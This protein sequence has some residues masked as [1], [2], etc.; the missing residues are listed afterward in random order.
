MAVG[1]GLFDLAEGTSTP[2]MTGLHSVLE[3][4]PQEDA[5]NIGILFFGAVLV[6]VGYALY[7]K[8]ERQ[9]RSA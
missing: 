5:W 9:A 7:K 2:H 3:L 8:G 1:P 6:M 4:S